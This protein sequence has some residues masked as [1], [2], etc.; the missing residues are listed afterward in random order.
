[1]HPVTQ[2]A[3]DV[4]S[5]RQIACKKVIQACQRHLDDLNR[6]D[7]FFDEA[8]ANRVCT[9]AEN[10]KHI[11]GKWD[12]PYIQLEPWQKFVL[13]SVFGWKRKESG[14]RRYRTVYC[15]IAR[16]NGKSTLGAIIGLYMMVADGEPGAEVYS[17]ATTREQA[18]IIFNDAKA[19]VRA[20]PALKS[21]LGVHT[22]N[23]H[24]LKTASK[25]EPVSSDAHTLDG[26]NVHCALV[27]ELHAHKDSKVWDVLDTGT[28]SRRQPLMAAIT[29]AGFERAVCIEKYNYCE[30]ILSGVVQDDTFFSFITEIDEGD[31]WRLPES[32]AKANPN[33]GVSV[34][35]EQLEA[36]CHRAQHIPSEQNNF[37]T[38]HL[39]KWCNQSERW[40]NLDDWKANGGEYD[41][42]ALEGRECFAGLD[43][44][45]TTDI[46]A[47]VL[48]FPPQE[49]GEQWKAVYRFWV[50]Q[51][52]VDKR[53]KGYLV[54]K[55]PF[56]AWQRDGWIK[57]TPGNVI[58]YEYVRKEI[59]D[60]AERFDVR[61]IAFDPYNCT[62]TAQKLM[63]AGMEMIEFRQ[64]A[65]SFH[66]PMRRFE[67]MML[68]REI[69]HG[70]HPA[71]TW[72]ANNMVVRYDANM[73][74]AP[75]KKSAKDRIDGVV[76]YLMALGRAIQKEN[77]PEPSIEVWDW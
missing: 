40:I 53:A 14:L 11:K 36:L 69:N 72:M 34:F 2:Y 16:K 12:N 43:L 54:D 71:M 21:R 45:A 38:K 60:L 23:I 24:D 47:L 17:A 58:D 28:G 62:E 46:T 70:N 7:L 74:M 57:A 76:A 55:V 59:L 65:R 9:F 8:E 37:L 19:M 10:L 1:V 68:D 63:E 13:G 29:T 73:N 44:S 67:G 66:E 33:L 18:R 4:V 20:Q 30:Q 75:D 15:Q 61:E 27:D 41:E 22:L 6:S 49:K 31:D 50:P 51:E 25:F 56:D 77:L 48:L 42:K 26:L 39:N 3:Q 5:G 64:G 52:R 32:W 35:K